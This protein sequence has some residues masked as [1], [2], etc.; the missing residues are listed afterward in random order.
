MSSRAREPLEMAQGVQ[1]WV[2]AGEGESPPGGGAR[3]VSPDGVAGELS[4]QLGAEA[5]E[6]Q[7]QL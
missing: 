5:G 3:T 1:G 4:T 6:A 7:G 2:P